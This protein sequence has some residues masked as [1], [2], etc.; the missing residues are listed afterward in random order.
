M[1][2]MNWRAATALDRLPLLSTEDRMLLASGNYGRY[3]LSTFLTHAGR[4]RARLTM[5]T[6][7]GVFY[8]NRTFASVAAAKRY[9][10]QVEA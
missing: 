7:R 8:G 6:G 9:V 4:K 10:D 2:A 1:V 3:I 5:Y